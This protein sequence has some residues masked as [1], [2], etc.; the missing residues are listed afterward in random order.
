MSIE[1]EIN[2]NHYGS[3]TIISFIKEGLVSVQEVIDSERMSKM[4]DPTPLMEFINEECERVLN[5]KCSLMEDTVIHK[6]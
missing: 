1:Y 4:F 3:D 2:L 6:G 5:I